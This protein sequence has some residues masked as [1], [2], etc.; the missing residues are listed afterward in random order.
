M[1]VCFYQQ[2]LDLCVSAWFWCH[3]RFLLCAVF[4]ADG[5]LLGGVSLEN[6]SE[7]AVVGEVVPYPVEQY[8]D[9]VTYREDGA[10]VYHEP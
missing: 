5:R 2:A 1:L 8:D 9:L 4:L 10:Q 7:R 6:N 3:A